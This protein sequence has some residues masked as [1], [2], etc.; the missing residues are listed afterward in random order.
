M[1]TKISLTKEQVDKLVE[2]ETKALQIKFDREVASLRKKYE[3]VEIE[4][5][6]TAPL[7]QTKKSKLT[8][9]LLNEY[10]SKGMSVKEIAE[11]SGFNEGYVY[12][13]KKRVLAEK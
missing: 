11:L 13:I 10:L 2:T 4:I 1:K 8:D 3:V 12:K 7:K 6:S 9:E 5:D